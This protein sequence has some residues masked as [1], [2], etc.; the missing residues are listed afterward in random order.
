MRNMISGNQFTQTYRSNDKF[1]KADLEERKM[2]YLYNQGEEYHFMDSQSYEQIFITAEQLGDSVNFMVDNMDV[3]VLF[4]ADKPIDV[5]LPIFVNLAVVKADPWVKGDTSGTDTK[6]VTVE[7]GYILQLRARAALL[8][9]LRTFFISR[10][11]IEV[12]TPLRQLTVIP[13][14]YILP[15]RS[16]EC[17]LQSSPELYM[18]RLLAAG[19]GDIFQICKCFRKDEKGMRHLEEFTMLE[20][21]RMGGDYGNLMQDCED[22]LRF[23]IKETAAELRACGAREEKAPAL[24]QL[25]HNDTSWDRTSVASAFVRYAP[26]SLEQAMTSGSF[27]QHLVEYIE[28]HLGRDLPE[29]LL[30][31]PAS[32]AS[33]ARLKKE[34]ASL[35][36]R[37]ELYIQGVELANG[38]S[39]LVD[40]VEQ[41]QRFALEAQVI[42][43]QGRESPALPQSFLD[44]LNQL[45]NCAG[46]A[47]GVDRLFMLML[48]KKSIADAIAFGP[49]EMD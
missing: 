43:E 40:P 32:L 37:F 5:S 16:E 35:A 45:D 6:P 3:D 31:Y 12:E 48:G 42:V 21:Y 18:K 29:F 25:L 38:F 2:Q 22:L 4:F 34:D 19:S 49:G 33:L 9:A 15:L 30:D 46:I 1:E 39:E 47:L 41:A 14:A 20:W 36:E 10:N 27:D 26:L 8:Q 13:E 17:Y 28:P 7:T 23:C 44:A 11:F 24:W